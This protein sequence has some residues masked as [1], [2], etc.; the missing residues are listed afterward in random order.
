MALSLLRQLIDLLLRCWT[1]PQLLSATSD[2]AHGDFREHFD[3]VRGVP[4]HRLVSRFYLCAG[5]QTPWRDATLFLRRF[6]AL[7]E[8][9]T[10]SVVATSYSVAALYHF[11]FGV[12]ALLFDFVATDVCCRETDLQDMNQKRSS[13]SVVRLSKFRK[14]APS[15]RP[16]VF[17]YR[18]D[19]TASRAEHCGM[20]PRKYRPKQN[21]VNLG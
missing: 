3:L 6:E 5:E 20:N 9:A 18:I 1:A 14:L 2:R 17:R 4:R 19:T 10:V 13:H 8:Q 21:K 15:A 7:H 12:R 16:S 11:L